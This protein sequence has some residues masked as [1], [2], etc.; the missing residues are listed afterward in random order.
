MM[1]HS[2]KVFASILVYFSRTQGRKKAP[3]PLLWRN[4]HGETVHKDG[5]RFLKKDR[6]SITVGESESQNLSYCLSCKPL[7]GSVLLSNQIRQW[8]RLFPALSLAFTMGLAGGLFLKGATQLPF[9]DTPE[10]KEPDRKMHCPE[11]RC[12]F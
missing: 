9:P 3:S 8:R 5:C 11:C 12:R 2:W 4:R 10:K 1:S 7:R 6:K